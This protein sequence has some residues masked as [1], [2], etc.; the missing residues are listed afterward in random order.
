MSKIV[1]ECNKELLPIMIW[2]ESI[3]PMWLPTLSMLR[4]MHS[5]A[6]IMKYLAQ[7]LGAAWMFTAVAIEFA[8]KISQYVCKEKSWIVASREA[9]LSSG[10]RLLSCGQHKTQILLFPLA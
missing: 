9:T 8:C 5:Y 10:K 2:C 3:D 4:V 6:V 7:V 1:D